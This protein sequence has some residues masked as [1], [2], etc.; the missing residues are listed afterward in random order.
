M[1]TISNKKSFGLQ[2]L[3][4]FSAALTLGV[5]SSAFSAATIVIQNNDAA[6][7]GFNDPT[8]VAPVG[9]NTGTTLGQQRL[10]AFQAAANTWGATLTSSVTI[11]VRA[12]WTALTCTTTSAVL[13][14]AGA[15]TIHR[16][17]AGVPFAGTWYGAA[18]ANKLNASDLDAVNPE[19][20][21]N[22]NVNLGNPGCLDG[23]P[24]YLG[25]DANHGTAVDLVTVLTHEFGHGLGF[26]T[27]TNGTTGATNSGFPTIYDRFLIDVTSGKSWLQMTDAER[28]A[29]ALNS[30]KLAWDGP[31]VLADVPSVL[32]AGTPFL[33]INAPAV[34]AGT[35]DVGAA[36]FGAALTA[37]GITGPVVQA[38]DPSD[39]AGVLTTDGCSPLTNAAAIAGN[40]AI[41]DRGTCG[42]AVKAKNAQDAGAIAVIIADNTAGSPPAGLG[43]TDPTVVIP[44][45]RVTLA[46]GTAIKAQ[47]GSGVNVT[48]KLDMAVRSGADPF[49]KPLL[50]TPNP[51]QSGSSVSHWDTST[52]PNQLM[53]P[54]INTDLTHN[55]TVPSDLTYSQMS[56]IGWIASVLPNAIARTA[57]DNQN[58]ALNTAFAVAPTVTA[59]PAASGLTVTWTINPNGSGAGATFASTGTRFAV[60]LTNASG[61]ATAPTL[62]ANG[63]PGVYSMNATIPGAGTTRFTLINDAVPVAGVACVADTTQADFQGGVVSNT[64]VSTSPGD[65][66]LLNPANLDQ[67][68]STLGT[69]GVGITITTWGGQT[70]TPAISGALK[71][72]DINLFC[73][74]CTGTTPA[75]T[76]SVRATSG[77][78][79]TG[80]DLATATINGFSS[81]ASGDYTAVF[82]TPAALTAGTMYAIVI[83]P[84]AN[85]SPGTYALTR[86]G[87]STTG[88]DVYAGG[89]RVAG[90]T[91]GTVWSIPLTGG[92]AT[93][94]GFR[95][96]MQTGNAP[97]GDFVSSAKDANPPATYVPFWTS[98]AWNATVPGGTTLQFQVAASNSFAG[99]FNFV[100]PDNTA[101][102]F[103][104]SGASLAQF[105]TFRYLK[106]KSFLTTSSGSTTPAVN[107]VTV[108]YNNAQRVLD[109]D[110]NLTYDAA[111][112]G[113]L[114]VRHLFGLTGVA[115]TNNALG[116]GF[117]AARTGDPALA[118]YLAG[119]HASLDVDGNGQVDALTDG[120]MIL[121]ALLGLP[122]AAIAQ[123]ATG[124]G[125]TRNA[126]AIEAY[127]QALKP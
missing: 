15:V 10:I 69:S 17:F 72:V 83:R 29:S 74:G 63:Q 3:A 28:A 119:I 47:L 36:S 98:L 79:P 70:F 35:Y 109:I 9:G 11:T 76:V 90:A 85:P 14:S 50:F 122:A 111:T 54:A 32:A 61:V 21:A 65:V 68:N 38:L 53:E 84:T 78:L 106:Y 64:D 51:F 93:D 48:L 117:N 62:N 124:V 126:A 89:S 12:Q 56:D 5:S 27:F 1:I 18:L 118:N 121:R 33:Q 105:N 19:I 99:P 127:I 60:S 24:F 92:I 55:V 66:I 120:L 96:Y 2:L 43:G 104:T 37:G 46:D 123:N 13:G 40:I 97:A 20:N 113:V 80:A 110:D 41:I 57:G 101:G 77:G 45:V 108:C 42:F 16:D 59:S 125:A 4:A 88:A 95:T 87:T 30:R 116:A 26:Q 58:T 67:Q 7:V 75:L 39:A 71:A 114:I 44:A 103:F 8:V 86:S 23:S 25:L 115:L 31:Q 94:A 52:F 91:S 49:G 82:A 100:G 6:G 102:T 81:G 107:D 112:D 34:I 73:S 22:F